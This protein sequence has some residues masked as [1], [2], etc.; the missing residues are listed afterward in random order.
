MKFSHVCIAALFSVL[1]LLP[2]KAATEND[3]MLANK[4][5]S[6]GVVVKVN[7]AECW[8]ED[9]KGLAGWYASYKKEL[10]ICAGD[11]WDAD[12][13]DTLRHEAHHFVQDC[14]AK[15]RFDGWLNTVYKEPVH[16]AFDVLPQKTIN[17]IL[18]GYKEDDVFLELE[19]WSVAR[20]NDYPEQIKDINTYCK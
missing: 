20:M 4:L 11:Q 10:V 18:K 3:I 16:L 6:K 17:M 13:S 8:S 2:A 1:P 15:D 7:D 9:T 12:D 14:F 5:K 19:A